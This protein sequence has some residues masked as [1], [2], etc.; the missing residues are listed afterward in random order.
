M[1][2][3]RE[4]HLITALKKSIGVLPQLQYANALRCEKSFGH[5]INEWSP[6]DWATA[7]AG[8]TGEL[9]NLIKKKR[10]GDHVETEAIAN[11]AADVVIYL[12][13]LCQRLG[14]NLGN[15]I[16]NKFNEV[17]EKRGS[18]VKIYYY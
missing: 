18:N 3:E 15:A 14:I 6:T 7:V 8:E 9:C 4:K 16:V 13:I 5:S 2:P 1:T 17:S 11:E 10:R 12:D